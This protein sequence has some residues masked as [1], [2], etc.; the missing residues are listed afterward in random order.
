MKTSIIKKMLTGVLAAALIM[1]PAMSVAAA[2]SSE[3]VSGNTIV[4]N[5]ASN[6][7]TDSDNTEV[8][9]DTGSNETDSGNTSVDNDASSDGTV[10]GNTV[11]DNNASSSETD[12]GSTGSNNDARSTA[13]ED[14]AADTVEEVPTSSAVAGVVSTTKGVYLATSVNGAAIITSTSAIVSGYGL[15]TGETPYVKMT[16]M[17]SEKSH[18]AKA[19]IDLAAASQG[20]EVGPMINL[21]LGKMSGGKY[22]LLASDGA[23]ITIAFG[24]PGNFARADK[25]FA[26]VCVRPGGVVSIL[27]DVDDNPNTVTFNTTGGAGVYA[28]IRY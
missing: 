7:E 27:P 26:V 13:T 15:A 6:S 10:S 11:V 28:I 20:A 1:A 5:D 4:D 8:D 17:D 14:A 22:S 16:N 21:E 25:T 3:T 24:I 18:L 12:S 23:A 9:N 2:N 19:A